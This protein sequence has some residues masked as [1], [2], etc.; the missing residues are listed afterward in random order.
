MK[1]SMILY[2]LILSCS[3]TIDGLAQITAPL[4]VL[5]KNPNY[6]TIDNNKAVYLTGS[7]SWNTLQDWGSNDSI[8]PIDFTAFVNML[9]SHHHN[10]TLLWT[11]ELP[12]FRFHH[13]H[14]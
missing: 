13:F 2:I 10:F 4:K 8:H 6:F 11:T 7:H 12:T 3:I 9:V 1:N 5:A 14:E